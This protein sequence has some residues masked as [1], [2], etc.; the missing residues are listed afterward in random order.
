MT[1]ASLSHTKT[2]FCALFVGLGLVAGTCL[3]SIAH[4]TKP[5]PRKR[6]T[7]LKRV[8][9]R[10][11]VYRLRW[12]RTTYQ[13][14]LAREIR[15]RKEQ[16]AVPYIL[17]MLRK[18]KRPERRKGALIALG[19]LRIHW[20]AP[21]VWRLRRDPAREV[22]IA[23]LEAM[24]WMVAY[25]KWPKPYAKWPKKWK[26]HL[27]ATVQSGHTTERRQALWSLSMIGDHA[28]LSGIQAA[29]QAST[30]PPGMG[31]DFSRTLAVL[32]D[33][34][35]RTKWNDLAKTRRTWV[36][37]RLRMWPG[38]WLARLLGKELQHK[39]R[40]RRL[41][42]AS[43]MLKL[44][45]RARLALLAQACK[46]RQLG[47]KTCRRV[48]REQQIETQPFPVS[49]PP[50]Y[51]LPKARIQTHH[52]NLYQ[53]HSFS[54][55]IEKI[56][57][58]MLGTPYVLDPLGEGKRGRYDKDPIFS[59]RRVDCVTFVE[60]VMGLVHAPTIK[61]A[62]KLTQR[63]RYDKGKIDYRYRRHLP[64]A[65]W[66]PAMM[67]MGFGRDITAQVGGAQTQQLTKVLDRKSYSTREGTRLTRRLGANRVVYGSFRLH[68]LTMDTALANL[69]KI[70]SGT[71]LSSLRPNNPYSPGQVTH[72]GLLVRYG[73]VLYMRHASSMW[74]SIV[75]VPLRT[76]LS[77]LKHYPKPRIGIH[78]LQLT[79][80]NHKKAN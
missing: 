61:Q 32:G 24:G 5:P 30:R 65:Q 18:R 74:R 62:I 69:H 70:P 10:S 52:A 17:G 27:L 60:Q 33:S 57:R 15:R 48:R 16:R 2:T 59:F 47:P 38:K 35:K 42:A 37:T 71:V 31:L 56:S 72:Q 13:R 34:A 58:R 41:R 64:I 79:P 23:A 11:L 51:L 26:A 19:Q 63:I 3:D 44:P 55:R 53:A 80:T 14:Q 54:G 1:F 73:G 45:T 12:N 66:L 78:L 25:G 49:L 21:E 9:W 75:D 22:R 20:T 6:S 50:F 67:K 68:Y 77:I 8:S 43:A 36:R 76:Y 29:Y 28:M 7:H 46:A 4:A 39:N 40:R